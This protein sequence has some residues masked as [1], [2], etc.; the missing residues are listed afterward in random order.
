MDPDIH[1]FINWLASSGSSS[2]ITSATFF[3][4]MRYWLSRTRFVYFI[5]TIPVCWA[6][7]ISP[8]PLISRSFSAILKPSCVSTNTSSLWEE[9]SPILSLCKSMQKLSLLPLPI[10]PLNWWSCARPNLSAFSITMISA[11]GISTPTST[12]VVETKIDVWL[13]LNFWICSCLSLAE[14]FPCR[15]PTFCSP[16]YSLRSS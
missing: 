15:H 16:K 13:S 8:G 1:L 5:G 12:T 4:P 6:P 7:I 11:S 14:S 2:Q 3:V 10:L 9:I